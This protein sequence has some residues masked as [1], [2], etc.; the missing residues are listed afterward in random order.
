MAIND[1]DTWC[2]NAYQPEVPPELTDTPHCNAIGTELVTDPNGGWSGAYCPD[3]AKILTE[4]GWTD[5]A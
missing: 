2:N 3:C 4:A 1:N 5:Q